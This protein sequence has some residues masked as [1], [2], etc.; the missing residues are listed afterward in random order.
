MNTRTPYSGRLRGRPGWADSYRRV[1]PTAASLVVWLD[2][3]QMQCCGEPFS[4]GGRVSWVLQP[5]GDP[6]FAAAVLGREL[7]GTITHREE[8][9]REDSETAPR[10]TGTVRSIRAASCTYAP[11]PAD[12][13]SWYPVPG[14]LSLVDKTAADGREPG[15]DIVQFV[16]YLVELSV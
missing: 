5:A 6:D 11:R 8:H 12:G 3:W 13:N 2:G 1:V 14:S 15:D 10:T 7:A 4:I 9:H 16:A